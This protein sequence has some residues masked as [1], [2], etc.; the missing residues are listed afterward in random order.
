MFTAA[1]SD[2]LDIKMLVRQVCRALEE[3]GIGR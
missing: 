2:E 1:D 3:K